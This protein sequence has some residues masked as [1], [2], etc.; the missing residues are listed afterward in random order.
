MEKPIL[1]RVLGFSLWC[2]EN[3]HGPINCTW[4]GNI[5]PKVPSS[6]V[7][8]PTHTALLLVVVNATCLCF[9]ILTHRPCGG[10]VPHRSCWGI[11]L[12][13]FL[14]NNTNI[15]KFLVKKILKQFTITFNNQ[16]GVITSLL[17]S[18]LKIVDCNVKQF[19]PLLTS[20]GFGKQT[21]C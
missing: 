1:E 15:I 10:R 14:Q 9:G 12:A 21:D 2:A 8:S 3:G 19:L 4:V 17:I 6:S 16:N 11:G 13:F 5:L 20:L 18:L 7:A